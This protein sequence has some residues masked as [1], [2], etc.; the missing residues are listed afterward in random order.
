MAEIHFI[1]FISFWEIE[2]NEKRHLRVASV[3]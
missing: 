1:Q 2:S 3:F